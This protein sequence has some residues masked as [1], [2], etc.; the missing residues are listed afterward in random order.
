IVINDRHADGRDVSWLWDVDFEM[1]ANGDA[2][3]AT[4]GIRGTDMTNRL[5]YAGVDNDRL[6]SYAPQPG[7]AIDAFVNS[8]PAGGSGYILA[9]YTAMLDLRANLAE[10]GAVER[11]WE[12]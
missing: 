7:P 3:L 1:L 9:T 8:L 2:P 5:H 6:T 4:S 12:Q 11:F 10:R